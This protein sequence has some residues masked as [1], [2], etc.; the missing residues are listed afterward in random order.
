MLKKLSIKPNNYFKP[1]EEIA[2]RIIKILQ[3][4]ST[5]VIGEPLT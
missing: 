1:S 5:T 2:Y 3:K 4:L